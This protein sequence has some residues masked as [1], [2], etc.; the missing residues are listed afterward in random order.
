MKN[1]R[2]TSQADEMTKHGW[3]KS[4]CSTPRLTLIKKHDTVPISHVTILYHMLCSVYT[5]LY[6]LYIISYYTAE[7]GIV[8]C[9][10]VLQPQ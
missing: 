2:E 1:I 8:P 6:T 3:K 4:W 7:Y 5:I 10:F 9:F